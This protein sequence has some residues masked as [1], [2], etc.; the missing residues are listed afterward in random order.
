[1]AIK[2]AAPARIGII[3]LIALDIALGVLNRFLH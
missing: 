1:M 2:N 3:G